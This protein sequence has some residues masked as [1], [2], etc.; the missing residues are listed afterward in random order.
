MHARTLLEHAA[1][2]H[3]SVSAVLPHAA[4]PFRAACSTARCRERWPPPHDA[5][6]RPHGCHAAR[7]HATLQSAASDNAGHAAPFLDGRV[8]MARVLVLRPVAATHSDHSLHPPTAQSTAHAAASSSGGHALPPPV[9]CATT[10]RARLRCSGAAAHAPHTAHS[11]TAQPR[12]VRAACSAPRA[13]AARHAGR[14]RTR[15]GAGGLHLDC[16][17]EARLVARHVTRRTPAQPRRRACGAQTCGSH[18]KPRV[19]R[20]VR[21][22][23]LSLIRRHTDAG[24]DTQTVKSTHTHAHQQTKTHMRT[25]KQTHKRTQTQANTDTRTCAHARTFPQTRIHVTHAYTDTDPIKAVC[26]RARAQ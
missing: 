12:V 16:G 18:A 8:T 19:H 25:N 9:G 11:A 17:V 10:E 3:A 21:P 1:G 20:S 4:P 22:H 5:E 15:H 14:A 24:T 26:V 6:H 2:L 13:C 23:S 7:T